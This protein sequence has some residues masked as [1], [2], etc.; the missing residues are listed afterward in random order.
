MFKLTLRHPVD[1][2]VDGVADVL[3]GGDEQTCSD[4]DDDGHLIV[5]PED[6]VVDAYSIKLDQVFDRSKCFKHF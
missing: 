2:T 5:K 1:Y 3:L 4:Q 6:V